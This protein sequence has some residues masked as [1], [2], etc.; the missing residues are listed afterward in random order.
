MAFSIFIASMTSRAS[1]RL[2]RVAFLHLDGEHEAGHG[3][4]DAA[5]AAAPRG[6]AGARRRRAGGPP[7]RRR[8]TLLTA[9]AA[10]GLRPSRT[11]STAYSLPSTTTSP[12]RA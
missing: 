2:H 4:R 8:A 11:R 12:V 6:R 9:A 3:R 5:L 10:T 7:G 1:T